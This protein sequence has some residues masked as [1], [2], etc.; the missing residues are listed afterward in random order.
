MTVVLTT[1]ARLRPG[2]R[3]MTAEERRANAVPPAYV[4]A[5]LALDPTQ[6]LQV[7]ATTGLGKPFYKYRP[8]AVA[9]RTQ[10]KWARMHELMQTVQAHAI[11]I[12]EDCEAGS[13]VALTAR[14]ILLSGMRIGNAGQSVLGVDSF[15]A[16][17]LLRRHV[18]LLPDFQI[19]F[20]FPGKKGVPQEVA[21]TDELLWRYVKTDD[22]AGDDVDPDR[23]LF[24]HNANAVL[25]YLKRIGLSKAHDLRTWRANVLAEA[26]LERTVPA[27][28]PLTK[29]E[30][31]AIRKS[32]AENVGKA[33]G[34]NASQAL[35][36]YINPEV[37][38]KIGL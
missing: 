26:L 13:V 31:K 16:S 29:R 28:A 14:L 25:R 32:V 23:R 10:Q 27:E 20:S 2:F 22:E 6:A 19:F 9:E 8:E 33:L 12:E 18:V 34:N 35:K 38:K 7:V 24:P 30:A 36:S 21:V 4:D 3:W 15:G 37:W 11:T 17:N 5:M 1:G